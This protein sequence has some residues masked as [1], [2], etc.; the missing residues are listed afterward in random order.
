MQEAA[1][2][3]RMSQDALMRKA[4][5]GIVPGCRPGRQ[6]VFIEADLLAYLRDLVSNRAT[7]G[8]VIRA[9]IAAS[10]RSQGAAASAHRL[11]DRRLQHARN[12]GRARIQPGP[13]TSLGTRGD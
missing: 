5:A 10:T 4:R 6:W 11:L 2:L 7:R 1:R 8:T 13:R 12:A 3:L 9:A